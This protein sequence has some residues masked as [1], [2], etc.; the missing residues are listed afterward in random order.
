MICLHFLLRKSSVFEHTKTPQ[1]RKV[2]VRKSGVSCKGPR[3]A[4]SHYDCF[5]PLNDT[6]ILWPTVEAVVKDFVDLGVTPVRTSTLLLLSL[7]AWL[8][9]ASHPCGKSR[10]TS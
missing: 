10:I 1:S 9:L 6:S 8:V 5:L 7:Q 3:K 2:P 4:F